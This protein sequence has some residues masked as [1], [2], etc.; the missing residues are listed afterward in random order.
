MHHPPRLERARPRQRACARRQNL[1]P[2][3]LRSI[4]HGCYKH[5]RNR[6]VSFYAVTI[7]I[8]MKYLCVLANLARHCQ[9]PLWPVDLKLCVDVAFLESTEA[10][11]FIEGVETYDCLTDKDINIFL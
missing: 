11:G 9:H 3:V 6:S 5:T 10:L 7:S 4:I 1:C 8:S 2:L